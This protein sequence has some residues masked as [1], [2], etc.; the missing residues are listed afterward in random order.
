[1]NPGNTKR[2]SNF[3]SLD[4]DLAQING[5]QRRFNKALTVSYSS[6]S[7]HY[8]ESKISFQRE[9]NVNETRKQAFEFFLEFSRLQEHPDRKISPQVNFSNTLSERSHDS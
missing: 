3:E 2:R 8:V 5:L 4:I 6:V 1:M 7:K 9:E